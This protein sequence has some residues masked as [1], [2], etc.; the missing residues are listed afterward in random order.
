VNWLDRFVQD[1]RVRQAVRVIPADARVLDVGCADGAL[2]RRLGARLRDG[3]GLDPDLPA[4]IR[5]ERY[6]LEAGTFPDDG[7]HPPELFDV[8]TMLAVL[9]HVPEGEQ[10]RVA[11]AAHDLL[12][13]GGLFVLTVP[14]PQVDRLLDVLIRLHVLD[15][16]DAEAHHGFEPDDVPPLLVR[17]GFSLRLRR[18]FQL[19]LNNLFVF[20][21]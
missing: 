8:V 9:E 4:P 7:P 1:R 6:R 16:M 17:A 20:E 14:S 18:R 13:P 19:G 12:R 21:R 11:Q 5:T 15:G 10:K 3:F 2:F